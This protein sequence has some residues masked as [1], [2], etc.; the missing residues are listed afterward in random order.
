[1][2]AFLEVSEGYVGMMRVLLGDQEGYLGTTSGAK[3]MR[4]VK[5]KPFSEGAGA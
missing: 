3:H 4:E 5:R 2:V 1:L